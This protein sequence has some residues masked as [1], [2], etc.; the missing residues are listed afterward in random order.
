[1]K[2]SQ[3]IRM[4]W[5]SILANKLRTALSM[6]GILIGV[7]TVISLVAMGQ[8]SANEVSAQ[9][10]GLGTN[11]LSVNVTG[12]GSSTTLTLPQAETLG[13]GI[14]GI[15]GLSP[16]VSGS[17]AARY[18]SVQTESSVTVEGVTPDYEDVQ[19]F[20]PQE[21]R[22]IAPLDLEA[23]SKVALLGIDTSEELFGPGV[24]PVGE[25]ILLSGVKYKVVG[26]LEPKGTSLGASND[27]KILVPITTAQRLFQSEGVRTVAVK[28]ASEE[29]MDAVTAALEAKL[30][31]IFRGNTNS[32]RITNSEELKET[33]TSVSKTM[34]TMMAGVAAI[35]LL[36]GGIGIMNI[37]LVSVT[38]RTREIGIRKALGARKRDV[39]LQFLVEAASISSL[40]GALG[41]AAAFGAAAIMERTG[42]AT[43]IESDI[44]L[45]SF[46]F[47]ALVGI[48]F[49]LFP[50]NKAASLKPV[51][52]LRHD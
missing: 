1:M 33:A 31:A 46:V 14:D 26:L 37:M 9:L 28:A 40:G 51:D 29:T 43:Q 13:D 4:A 2:L 5:S 45:Y 41:I 16:T 17:A 38:E 25:T 27:E 11:M 10:Q 23:Y 22:F 21:G 3:G 20:H 34:S 8:G 50:A 18:G 7:A 48:V 6:L 24:S 19:D 32:Y 44:V 12:R 36:V 39:L 52:A 49:G 35:S 30:S 47:S 42:T 15:D